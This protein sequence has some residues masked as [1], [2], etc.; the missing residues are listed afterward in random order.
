MKR[1]K[2][3]SARSSA[4]AGNPAKSSRTGR[5]W[6]TRGVIW[7]IVTM[8]VGSGVLRLGNDTGWA[9]ANGLSAEARDEPA[10]G[11]ENCGPAPDVAEVLQMLQQRENKIT[12]REQ[13]IADRAQALAVS[14]AAIKRQL[15][16]LSDA[17]KS[18]EETIAYSKTANEQDVARLTAVYENMKAKEAAPLFAAMEPEFAAGFLGRMRPESAAAIL[19]RLDPEVAYSVSVLLAG[20]NALAPTQ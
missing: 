19:A 14:E 16:A 4:K 9:I 10:T 2:P 8:L 20:R 11:P 6:T 18:L 15:A 12:E 3:S 13:A 7:I 1:Q 17:R 5:R